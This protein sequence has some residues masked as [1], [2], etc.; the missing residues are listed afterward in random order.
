LSVSVRG[1]NEQS[2][3]VIIGGSERRYS[4]GDAALRTDWPNSTVCCFD[5]SSDLGTLERGTLKIAVDR[6]ATVDWAVLELAVVRD[7][8]SPGSSR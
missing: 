7:S 8:K 5:L 3:G 2:A 4:F 1:K 6:G